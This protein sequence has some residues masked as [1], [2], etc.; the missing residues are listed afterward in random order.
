MNEWMYKMIA[1]TTDG[2]IPDDVFCLFIRA[3]GCVP[4]QCVVTRRGKTYNMWADKRTRRKI[5]SV[6][7]LEQM[8]LYE[9]VLWLYNRYPC[10]RILFPDP[11]VYR[12]KH[13]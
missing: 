11:N 7:N 6:A 4:V 13:R 8:T 2:K 12:S 1:C 9:F 5:I 10:A 3:V